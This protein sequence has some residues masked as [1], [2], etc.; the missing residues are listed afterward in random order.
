MSEA[1]SEGLVIAVSGGPGSGKSTLARRLANALGLRYVS[2]G[3]LFRELARERGFTLEEFSRIAE[4]DPS[5]D[6]MIDSRAREEG[7]KGCVVVDA[8]IAAW[9][10][11]GI[12]HL[13]IGVIAPMEVRARRIAERDGKAFEDALREVRIREES[14]FKRFLNY[15]GINVR[16]L[17]VFDLIINTE[18]F[19]A[20]EVLEIALTA[21]KLVLSKLKSGGKT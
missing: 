8:H 5:I 18:K 16:D 20:D 10:L 4:L 6:L 1:C 11:E 19:N 14:E 9:V 7:K 15:Y 2:S 13:K 17:S 21:S 12:A 3:Q